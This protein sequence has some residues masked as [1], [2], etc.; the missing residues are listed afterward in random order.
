MTL[1]KIILLLTT[2]FCSISQANMYIEPLVGYHTGKIDYKFKPTINGGAS[3][4]GSLNGIGYG[5]GLG[6]IFSKVLYV[7]VE[8]QQ[9]TLTSKFET[10]TTETEQAQFV[11]YATVGYVIQPKAR[12]YLGI[13]SIN[14]KND[15]TPET[16]ATGS[17]LKAGLTY[18]FKS[19]I[20][21]NIEYITYS[22]NEFE[23]AGSAAVKTTDQYERYL[24]TAA[25]WNFR[26]PFEF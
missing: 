25:V 15:Q 4:K 5:L 11:G 24:T 20:A 12:V 3:D 2:L 13:G 17:A 21:A 14:S 16:T 8:A 23:T 10:S 9:F 26:F 18:E 7:G 6:W 19:H 22:I 1:T